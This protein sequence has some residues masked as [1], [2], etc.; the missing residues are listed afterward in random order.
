[1]RRPPPLFY[2]LHPGHSHLTAIPHGGRKTK[3]R[4]PRGGRTN[5]D[6]N[7]GRHRPGRSDDLRPLCDYI[8]HETVP[9]IRERHTGEQRHTLGGS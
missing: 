9:L 3:S 2:T 1:M 7:F 4:P 6:P 8:L 5:H